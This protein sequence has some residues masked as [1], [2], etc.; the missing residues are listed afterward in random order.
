MSEKPRYFGGIDPGFTGAIALISVDGEHVRVWDIPIL[1][2]ETARKREVELPKLRSIFRTL[3]RFNIDTLGIEWPTTRPGEPPEPAERFGRQKG[4]LEAMAVCHMI[5][6]R[7][8]APNL[9]TGRLNVPGKTHGKEHND[10]GARIFASY[11][12][13]HIG[14][15]YGPRGGVKDGR[16]D[17]LLIAHWLRLRTV[18]GMRSVR[19]QFGKDSTEAWGA[20]LTGRTK[21][22]R[23]FRVD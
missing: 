12:S 9:W 20:M 6:H 21:K 10:V 7:R 23:S 18:D 13:D 17:A 16:L 2:H 11:Y 15:I 5:P 3:T 1:D 4:Y 8:V 19:D 22:R 14:L